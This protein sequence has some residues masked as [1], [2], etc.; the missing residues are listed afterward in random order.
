ML[1][2]LRCFE[3]AGRHHSV[4]RAAAELCISQGAVSQQIKQLEA[5]LGRTLLLRAGRELKLSP[6]GLQLHQ[7]VHEGW[8]G[9][10]AALARLRRSQE[11]QA[12]VLSCSPSFAMKWLTPRLSDFFGQHP[13]IPLS[14]QGE[15][16][17]VNRRRMEEEALDAAVRF[18]TGQ[19]QGL[20]MRQ[21]L[22]E[23]V[24]P[25]AS[26]AFLKAHP[27]LRTPAD[28]RPEWLLHDVSPW[29]GADAFR[30]WAQWFAAMGEEPRQLDGGRQFNLSLLALEA[31]VA[32][33]GVAMGRV[34]LVLD[35]I[36]NGRLVDLFST[37]VRS[38][39]AYYFVLPQ[40]PRGDVVRVESWLKSQADMFMAARQMLW[41]A[42]HV[43][44][45][46]T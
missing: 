32:G 11:P 16:H 31:A 9:I 36:R 5:A 34:A 41:D 18:D 3:A 15:F 1:A 2:W 38:D 8:R 12:V 23:W 45:D 44:G 20:Y 25:V 42:P 4:S 17:A 40:E 35:D 37:P 28:L 7:A 39:A 24:L 21:L 26:P 30:E 43:E 33:Q 22:D 10:E 6:D 29:D 27:G 46:E 14:V 19:Y 13:G